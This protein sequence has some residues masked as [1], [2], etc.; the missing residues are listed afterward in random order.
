M[1]LDGILEYELRDPHG[2]NG[3]LLLLHLG[4]Q[5]EDKMYLRLAQLIGE[6]RR[7]GYELVLVDDLL[8]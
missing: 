5:R 3:F 6:L 2:L 4:A 8:R 7:R 1:I